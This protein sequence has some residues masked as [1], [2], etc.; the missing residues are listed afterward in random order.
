MFNCTKSFQLFF[1]IPSKD[2]VMDS[3]AGFH[4]VFGFII[5]IS[6]TWYLLLAHFGV[7]HIHNDE[8]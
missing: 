7:L 4:S 2:L 1:W 8:W 5:S 3:E 6:V